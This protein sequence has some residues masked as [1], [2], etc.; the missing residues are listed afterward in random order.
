MSITYIHLPQPKEL[1]SREKEDAMGA[2]LMMFAAFA[3]SIPLPIVNLI[4]AIIYFYINR[5]KAV[6]S[7]FIT[8]NHYCLNCQQPL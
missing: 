6:I 8:F 7:I 3:V 5:K 4:A 2:Y 1:T